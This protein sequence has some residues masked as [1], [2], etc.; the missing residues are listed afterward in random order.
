[1]P[2]CAASLTGV[3]LGT[4]DY[5]QQYVDSRARYLDAAKALKVVFSLLH[6]CA[7]LLSA[8]SAESWCLLCNRHCSTPNARSLRVN[9]DMLSPIDGKRTLQGKP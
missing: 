7:R 4:Q 1:V 2:P 5:H 9:P 3:A 8:S 6:A